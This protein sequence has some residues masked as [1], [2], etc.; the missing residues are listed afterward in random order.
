MFLSSAD[1]D[2]GELLELPQECQGSIRVSG[3]KVRFLWRRSRGKGPRLVL[4]GEF[5]GFSRV[6]AGLLSSYN[7]DLTDPL[8]E[9]QGGP[10]S[11]RVASGPSA[12]LCS[13]CW[14]RGPHLKLRPEPQ[15]STSRFFEE[16]LR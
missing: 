16:S 2:V 13:R 6:L 15:G 1:R 12:F 5:P 7:G 14:G 8:L 10:V 3:G 9:P 11:T 4:R